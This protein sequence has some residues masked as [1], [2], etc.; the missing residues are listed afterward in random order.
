[1]GESDLHAYLKKVGETWLINQGCFL[2]GFE[3]P[4]NQLGLERFT[5][6]D[7][8]M[9]IDVLGLGLRYGHDEELKGPYESGRI[10]SR[11]IEVKVSRSDFRNGFACSGC[12]YHY[13]L[14]PM[15]MIAP[16][17][18]P[19]GIGLIEYNKHKF[20]VDTSEDPQQRPYKI[21][22]L[23]VVKHPKYKMI[24]RFQIDHVIAN[25]ATKTFIPRLITEIIKNNKG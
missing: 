15:R 12:N 18:V 10:V 2:T 9:V 6:L 4:L 3:V 13:L 19:S 14:T 25:L 17:E 8:K 22:G 7:N 24:P 23:R 20:S 16:T 1:M 5:D 21:S 11:G